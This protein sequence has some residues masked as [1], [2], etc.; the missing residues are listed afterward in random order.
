M[1]SLPLP[2]APIVAR[3]VS[4]IDGSCGTA[5]GVHRHPNK[6]HLVPTLQDG[7]AESNGQNENCSGRWFPA[8]QGPC[9][10]GEGRFL[11]QLHSL[12]DEK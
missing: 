8:P 5:A 12:G 11:V 2:A 6:P 7:C 9:L 10:S 1:V 3:T 4:N